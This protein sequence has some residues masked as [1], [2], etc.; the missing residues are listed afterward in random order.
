[1]GGF[2]SSLRKKKEKV[3]VGKILKPPAFFCLRENLKPVFQ[4]FFLNSK[5]NYM[6]LVNPKILKSKSPWPKGLGGFQKSYVIFGGGMSKY[7]QF[8]TGVLSST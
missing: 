6:L 8:L 3:Y 5:K 7:L 2:G 4:A 1:V